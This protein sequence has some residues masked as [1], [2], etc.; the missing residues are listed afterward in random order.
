MAEPEKDDVGTTGD[1]LSD[2]ASRETTGK[3]RSNVSNAAKGSADD[4]AMA[5]SKG[6]I[7]SGEGDEDLS[8]ASGGSVD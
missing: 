8:Q 3:G 1:G 5:G 4:N 7:V 6:T 2:G